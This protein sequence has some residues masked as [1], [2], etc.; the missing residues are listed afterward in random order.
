MTRFP[1]PPEP[2]IHFA[3]R[4]LMPIVLALCVLAAPARAETKCAAPPFDTLPALA[5]SLSDLSLVFNAFSALRDTLNTE[6]SQVCIVDPMIGARGYFEPDTGRL[7]LAADLPPGLGQA[8]LVHE[9]RHV[10]QFS[11]GTCPTPALT[12]QDYAQ[13]VFAMEADASVTSL[14]VADFL[15]DRGKPAMWQALAEWPMQADIAAAYDAF[16]AQGVEAAAAAAF[17]A[18]YDNE[19]RRRSYYAST[20]LDYLDRE[21]RSHRL[22]AQGALSEG[23]YSRLCVLPDG[24]AYSCMAPDD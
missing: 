11:L 4:S 10:Q 8:V 15:R 14:V 16:R 7:M 3:M 24:R 12:M 6:V 21:E 13:A 17:A 20:C 5:Q 23:F 22:P 1:T 2:H 19:D 9:L 18:W